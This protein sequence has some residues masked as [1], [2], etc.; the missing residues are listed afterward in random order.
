MREEAKRTAMN[1]EE[2]AL[3]TALPRRN[4]IRSN[5]LR[6]SLDA[7]DR[8]RGLRVGRE[9]PI[10]EEDDGRPAIIRVSRA[11]LHHAGKR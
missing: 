10:G 1:V 9:I 3:M 11:A 8:M 5:G 4:G 6:E 2:A 7:A